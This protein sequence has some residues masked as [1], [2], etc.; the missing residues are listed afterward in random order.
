MSAPEQ[1][2]FK[3]TAPHDACPDADALWAFHAG[4]L[5]AKRRDTVKSHLI[6]CAWCCE[7]I[8]RFGDT[9]EGGPEAGE[10][11][12]PGLDRKVRSRWNP[13]LLKRVWASQFFWAV[14]FLSAVSVSF[15]DPR[16]YKQWLVIA[17][18]T[19]VRWALSERAAKHHLLITRKRD[20]EGGAPGGRLPAEREAKEKNRL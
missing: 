17:L 12:P 10:T 4:E 5:D 18:V 20:A 1:G 14:C 7:K 8:A 6:D 13:S 9:A 2:W 16:H 19:G 15:A 11:V 3:T